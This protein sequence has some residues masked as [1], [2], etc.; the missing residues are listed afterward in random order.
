MPYHNF[1]H[2]LTVLE[3]AEAL[4]ER[5]RLH[6]VVVSEE[7]LVWA[8]LF[9]DANYGAD[10][11][12]AGYTSMEDMHASIAVDEMRRHS[13]DK[14]TIARAYNAIRSTNWLVDPASAEDKILRASDLWGLGNDVE[15]YLLERERVM[16]EAEAADEFV[17]ARKN[18]TFLSGYACQ[19]IQ[20]TPEYFDSNGRSV[21]HTLVARNFAHAYL[22]CCMRHG[23]EPKIILD[24]NAAYHPAF[25]FRDQDELIIGIAQN[26]MAKKWSQYRIDALADLHGPPEIF[27]PGTLEQIP[28]PDA[29]CDQIIMSE[30]Q[31]V[32]LGDNEK[33]E[34]AR[35]A[36][37]DTTII[38]LS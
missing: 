25:G 1:G 12:S 37:K 7:S 34:L 14:P 28:V 27:L 13:V 29:F 20:L 30:R 18:F 22:E 24:A 11:A 8:A 10:F 6:N 15:T 16:R 35:V 31:L 33:T 38:S 5:C 2:A 17:F 9:H 21:W 3:R 36:A 19:R 23:Q 32:G 4:A 26:E